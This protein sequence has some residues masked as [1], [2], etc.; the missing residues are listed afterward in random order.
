VGLDVECVA[1]TKEHNGRATAQIALVSHNEQPILNLCEIPSSCAISL[2]LKASPS[3]F[4][5]TAHGIS[6]CTD[7]CLGTFILL[8]DS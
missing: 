3:S 8:A 5:P 1:T 6:T 7:T 4:P 2:V